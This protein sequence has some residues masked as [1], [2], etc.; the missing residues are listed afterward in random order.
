M[1]RLKK[2]SAKYL[3]DPR[4]EMIA[5]LFGYFKLFPHAKIVE[6]DLR[7]SD[8]AVEE[9]REIFKK[10]DEIWR[11][12][13]MDMLETNALFGLMPDSLVNTWAQSIPYWEVIEWREK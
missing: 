2:V 10:T 6:S 11:K 7:F 13:C 5:D 1:D 12:L 3:A 8:G 4:K 9:I